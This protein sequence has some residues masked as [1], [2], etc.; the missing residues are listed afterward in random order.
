MGLAQGGIRI[1]KK[2]GCFLGLAQ[3]GWKKWWLFM[4]MKPMVES[5][6]NHLKSKSKFLN[7]KGMGKFALSVDAI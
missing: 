3:S 7:G 5:I 2:Y 4:V 6:E 1:V